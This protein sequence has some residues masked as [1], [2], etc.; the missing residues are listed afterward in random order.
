[1]APAIQYDTGNS[2]TFLP[3]I[4]ILPFGVTYE[5]TSTPHL[6]LRFI[7]AWE[8]ACDGSDVSDDHLLAMRENLLALVAQEGPAT[9]EDSLVQEFAAGALPLFENFSAEGQGGPGNNVPAA[10]NADMFAEFLSSDTS[11]QPI[12]T[13]INGQLNNFSDEVLATDGDTAS[14]FGAFSANRKHVDR[15]VPSMMGIA[16]LQKGTAA[17]LTAGSELLDLVTDDGSEGERYIA[18]LIKPIEVESGQLAVI[19]ITAEEIASL[20]GV[21]AGDVLGATV[22]VTTGLGS[23]PI[24]FQL[25]SASLELAF[26]PK[27]AS[28]LVRIDV[29]LSTASGSFPEGVEDW[30]VR[31]EMRLVKVKSGPPALAVLAGP[32]RRP[33]GGPG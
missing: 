23:D 12:N 17:S 5:M 8:G 32:G 26:E 4:P 25:E 3:L 18:P 9:L 28:V 15:S 7:R 20:V 13:S 11:D 24:P 1:M 19:T 27:E 22:Y 10:S 16:A 30:V 31:P 6:P 21:Q 33:T 14:L 2:M 29:D